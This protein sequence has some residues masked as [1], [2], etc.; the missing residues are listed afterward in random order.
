MCHFSVVCSPSFK[1]TRNRHRICKMKKAIICVL[2]LIWIFTLSATAEETDLY[3]EQLEQ[4]GALEL[5][6]SLSDQVKEYLEQNDIDITDYNWVNNLSSENVFAHIWNFLRGGFKKPLISLGLIVAIVLISA[7]LFDTNNIPVNSAVIYAATLA[8][9][10]IIVVPVFSS[11]NSAVSAMKTCAT[12][13]TAFVPVFAVITTASG[14]AAT[15][16]TM[17]GLLLGAANGVS[18]LSNYVVVPLIGG[19]LSVSIATGI[20]PF[21]NN[22]GLSAAIKKLSLWIVSFISTIFLGILSIQ[23]VVNSAADNLS[24][25]TAKFIIGSSVPV[26]GGILSEALGTL[27]ASM[28]L[29]KS[30]V[31]IYGVVICAVIFIPILIEL[32]L[33]R[34]SLWVADFIALNFSLPKI[35]SLIQAIDT[36]LSVLI[37]IILLTGAMFIISLTVVV[38]ST[39]T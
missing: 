27:T 23:T 3:K 14:K 1:H 6:D 22:N 39:R 28:S 38:G 26:A 37:G 31:G 21:L 35:S 30:S 19:Y 9:A 25:R 20:S 34:F 8:I 11:I 36:V 12:F 32:I 24:M 5:E 17:S 2:F 4:S 16:V 29:L 15:S 18:L 33:W 7:A 13:M 10:G